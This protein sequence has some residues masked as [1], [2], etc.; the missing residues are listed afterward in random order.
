MC[1]DYEVVAAFIQTLCI[2]TLRSFIHKQQNEENDKRKI[3]KKSIN[4]I[5]FVVVV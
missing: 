5:R 1:I 3:K 2:F 4:R